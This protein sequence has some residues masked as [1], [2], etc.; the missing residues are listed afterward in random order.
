MQEKPK[1]YHYMG[2]SNLEQ[3]MRDGEASIDFKPETN[4]PLTHRMLSFPLRNYVIKK[5]KEPLQKTIENSKRLIELTPALL[6]SASRL[7]SMFGDITTGNTNYPNTHCLIEHKARFLAHETCKNR[8]KLMEAAYDIG[9]AEI[10]HD[11][12]YRERFDVEIEW[13]VEDILAGKWEPRYEGC[14][15]RDWNEPAPYGGKYSIV[16]KLRKHREEILKIIQ[17]E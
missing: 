6:K 12:H 10:E 15:S 8:V 13:I 9:I 2:S 1:Y 14:T 3:A 16:F 4:V 7:K 11:K 17:E 5:I